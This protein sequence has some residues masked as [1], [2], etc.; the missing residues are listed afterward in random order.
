LELDPDSAD[1]LI[2]YGYWFLRARGRFHETREQY[3]RI[4]AVDPLS[5]IALFAIAEA[6]FFEDKFSSVIEYSRKA[7][8]IEPGYWPPLT[9]MASS[10][11]YLGELESAVEWIERAVALA[12]QDFTVRS[13]A[14]QLQAT[15]GNPGPA[16]LLINQLESRTGWSRVPAMLAMLY[17]SVG[18]VDAAFRCAEEMIEHRSAR[19]FWIMGPSYPRLRRH[20]R[21]PELLRRMN[22]DIGLFR[23]ANSLRNV[24]GPAPE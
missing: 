11:V 19:V 16:H 5:S 13:I 23:P 3:R 2:L 20:P 18:N 21:F 22:L 15:L 9:M 17:D 4:L 12:P 8:E 7:L 6:Y 10:Y 1:V 24:A 14:A